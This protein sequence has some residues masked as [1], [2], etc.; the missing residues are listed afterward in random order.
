MQQNGFCFKA[1]LWYTTVSG[2][3]SYHTSHSQHTR[4]VTHWPSL[5]EWS[6]GHRWAD[7]VPYLHWTALS[8]NDNQSTH[9]RTCA[10]SNAV[11]QLDK[12]PVCRPPS[13]IGETVTTEQ[14]ILWQS[15]WSRSSPANSALIRTRKSLSVAMVSLVSLWCLY[16]PCSLLLSLQEWLQVS[17]TGSHATQKATDTV[18]AQKLHGWGRHWQTAGLSHSSNGAPQTRQVTA[19]QPAFIQPV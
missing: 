8:S 4:L 17:D 10:T 6:R 11:S 3:H 5:R 7:S 14:T 9:T 18:P 1:A 16:N 19:S 2:E 13:A 15:K 12:H